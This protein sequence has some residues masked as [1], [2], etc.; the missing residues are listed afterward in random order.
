MST[1]VHPGDRHPEPVGRPL[2]VLIADDGSEAA[3]AATALGLRIAG[4]THGEALL[5]HAH[6]ERR[7]SG[8]WQ[9]H[10]E[11]AAGYAPAH[12]RAQTRL[13]QGDPARVILRLATDEGADVICLGAAGTSGRLS[14]ML[15][16]VSSKVVEHA[17]CP[18]LVCH[19]G[20]HSSPA[21]VSTVVVGLDGS[22]NAL[23]ALAPA[24]LL[25]EI[26]DA[27][28]V[29]LTAYVALGPTTASRHRSLEQRALGVLDEAR[30][31]LSTRRPVVEDTVEGLPRQAL[32]DAARRHAPSI[33]VLGR[34]GLG[35]LKERL[36]GSTTWSTLTSA[37]CPVLVVPPSPGDA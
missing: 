24:E 35:G 22:A 37:P 13:E 16:S 31:R 12:A 9:R 1:A 25:T 2:R 23:D 15:G 7:P 17:T 33:L 18:V 26:F 29:L 21:H 28:L 5:V 6:A 10:L 19:A 36:I 34:E 20:V 3:A 8:Y 27:T 14:A 30:A 4:R 11:N 32:L